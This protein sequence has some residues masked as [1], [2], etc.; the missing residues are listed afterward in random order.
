MA[1]R[2][3]ADRRHPVQATPFDRLRLIGMVHLPALPGSSGGTVPMD[4]IIDR[5]VAEA[6]LLARSGFDALIVEN[7]GDAPFAADTV[8]PETVAAMALVVDR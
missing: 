8:A 7:F 2:T 4:R 6:D 5:A 3:Q 1:K